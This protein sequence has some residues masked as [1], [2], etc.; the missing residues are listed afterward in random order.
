MCAPCKRYTK[1]HRGATEFHRVFLFYKKYFITSNLNWNSLIFKN[2]FQAFQKSYTKTCFEG[3]NTRLI[4]YV[5]WVNF[6]LFE[7]FF[8]EKFVES[9]KMT[10]FAAEKIQKSLNHCLHFAQHKWIFES[11]N[12]WI[13]ESLNLWIFESLNQ[14]IC[15]DGGIGRRASF[16]D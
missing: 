6:V 8:S 13:F 7:W 5:F 16:R 3:Y 1:T 12:F 4:L 2:G 15:P 10:N 14:N 9:K 11:L